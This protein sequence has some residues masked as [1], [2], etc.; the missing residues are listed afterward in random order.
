MRPFPLLCRPTL[1]DQPTNAAGMVKTR[2]MS[3]WGLLRSALDRVDESVRYS[4]AELEAIVG[5]LPASAANHRAWWSGDRTHVR[6]WRAAGF[7]AEDIVLGHEVTF[8]RSTCHADDAA[9][10]DRDSPGRPDLLLVACVKEKLATPAAAQDL[11]ASSLF[12]KE[13]AYAEASGVPWF[14]LS[15]EHG[16][17]APAEW[18][19][20]YDR[21][22]PDTP[23]SF[24]EAWAAWVVERL[25]L[26]AGSLR[27]KT[28]EIHAGASYV[29]PLRERLRAKGATVFAPLHGLSLGQRLAWYS[30]HNAAP[31]SSSS[32]ERPMSGAV[33]SYAALLSQPDDAISPTAFLA[34]GPAGLRVPGLYSWWVDQA[35][36]DDLTGG[37][38]HEIGPGL[39]YA[40]LAGATRWPSG[41]RSTNTLWARIAG[42]H[43][44]RRHE[45]STFRRTLGAVLADSD[46]ID[47]AQLT[48]WMHAHLRVLAVPFEDVEALGRLE[49]DVLGTLDPPL[50][51]KGM[52]TTPVRLRLKQLRKP[53]RR[54]RTDAVT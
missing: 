1:A 20:P 12:S 23:A 39:I 7:S 14:I 15:A 48:R 54:R 10:V 17:V 37:I 33:T 16:L 2:R 24:R 43:L 32:A 52:S 42:M 27:G 50:N 31:P 38:G 46:L 28:I 4:W 53:F 34:A 36:A 41:K 25:E 29:D 49:T 6:A 45:F 35:G 19:S 21:Y 22:L 40:G 47:E 8:V 18:L 51:L 9:P 30:A 44:G 5:D 3:D 13:R 11:Y 26:L